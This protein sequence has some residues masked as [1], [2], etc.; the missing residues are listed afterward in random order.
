MAS[1][2]GIVSI[3]PG[4]AEKRGSK[5]LPCFLAPVIGFFFMKRVFRKVYQ[6][7]FHRLY[8]AYFF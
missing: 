8:H 7:N 4:I 5:A 2:N 3:F 6:M 1:A